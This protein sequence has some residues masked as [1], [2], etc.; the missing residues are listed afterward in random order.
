MCNFG[1]GIWFEQNNGQKKLTLTDKM[2]ERRG[3]MRLQ[4]YF[5]IF[6]LLQR[7]WCNMARGTLPYD[8]FPSIWVP[9]LVYLFYFFF[10][11]TFIYIYFFYFVLKSGIRKNYC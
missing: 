4:E 7:C 5:F 11:F 10:E 3:L 6:K 1:V 9:H 2:R 8:P